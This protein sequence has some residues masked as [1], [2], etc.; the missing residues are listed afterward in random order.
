MK[1]MKGGTVDRL[2]SSGQANVEY[3]LL[4]IAFVS[5]LVGMGA[6][7]YAARDGTLTELA[8]HA[9]SHGLEEGYASVHDIISY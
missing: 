3:A 5:M 9:A 7:W 2:S 6:L 8:T 1:R 4:V